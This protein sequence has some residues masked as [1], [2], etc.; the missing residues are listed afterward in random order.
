MRQTLLTLSQ[1]EH[2]KD[3]F[4]FGS[5]FFYVK[6]SHHGCEN[7][8]K[9]GKGPV[10]GYGGTVCTPTPYPKLTTVCLIGGSNR[11]IEEECGRNNST[12]NEAPRVMGY[13]S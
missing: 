9:L 2:K 4:F 6:F 8:L 3:F 5:L 7:R 11:G 1:I 12:G 10:S 13:P